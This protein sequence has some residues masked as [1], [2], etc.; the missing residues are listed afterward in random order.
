M[1]AFFDQPRFKELACDDPLEMRK[2]AVFSAGAQQSQKAKAFS[3][4]PY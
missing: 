3:P 4:R 2:V 1:G